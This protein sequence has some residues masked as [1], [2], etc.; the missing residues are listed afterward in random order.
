VQVKRNFF[1][2][3]V[4][5]ALMLVGI[6]SGA[7]S[8]QGKRLA[9][10]FCVGKANLLPVYVKGVKV[11]RAGA[12]RSVAVTEQCQST[13]NRE[14]GQADNDEATEGGTA[15]PVGPAGPAGPKGDK[16]DTGATGAQGEKGDKGDA[17]EGGQGLGTLFLCTN[18]HGGSVK[19]ATDKHDCDP[20]HDTIYEIDGKLTVVD[21]S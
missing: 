19:V 2:V 10:P 18:E 17:G 8:D 9:G 1:I 13:E 14:F 12:V 15:G 11:I 16:G 6:A 20:G 4:I 3:A 21:A 5:A 7:S